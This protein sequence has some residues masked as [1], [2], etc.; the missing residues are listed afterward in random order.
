MAAAN[1][2]IYKDEKKQGP[3]DLVSLIKK[4]RN[5]SLG[6]DMLVASD[7]MEPIPADQVPELAEFFKSSSRHDENDHHIHGIRQLTLGKA[8]HAGVYFLQNN[9]QSAIYTGAF[10]LG[11]ILFGALSWKL[12]LGIFGQIIAS[13]VSY[14]LF[15]IYMLC[16]L[17]LTRGQTIEPSFIRSRTTSLIVPLLIVSAIISLMTMIGLAMLVIPGLFIMTLYIFTPLLVLD[18]GM[19]FWDAMETSRRAVLQGGTDLIGILFAMVVIIFVSGLC[20]ILPLLVV[21]P[22]AIS[23]ISEI[24]DEFFYH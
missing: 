12:G 14:T 8:L 10:L 21:L 22:I 2:Y 23:A 15:S 18:K 16:I 6:A 13:I 20:F 5:G 4:I 7:M 19:D 3:Y 17:R 1:Y 11:A 24:Y 9:Q